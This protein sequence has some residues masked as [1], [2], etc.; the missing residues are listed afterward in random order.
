VNDIVDMP[1]D[2]AK[3]YRLNGFPRRPDGKP[4]EYGLEDYLGWL[5]DYLGAARLE[6][7]PE[8][9][10]LCERLRHIDPMAAMRVLGGHA[11]LDAVECDE[12]PFYRY[13]QEFSEESDLALL[14]PLRPEDTE[15]IGDQ[16]EVDPAWRREFV[17]TDYAYHLRYG[18]EM[19]AFRKLWPEFI[20]QWNY[21][22]E[23][24]GSIPE[25]ADAGW[26][27]IL[28]VI[29]DPIADKGRRIELLRAFF[30]EYTDTV[31]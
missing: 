12:R 7:N 28:A 31:D 10:A 13:P 3:D 27:I 20:K 18:R 23:S 1:E 19:K 24:K 17:V 4:V 14:E 21:S 9:A 5:A 22:G 30:D 26:R 2:W 6:P 15:M 16:P 25:P 8:L 29:L 11:G